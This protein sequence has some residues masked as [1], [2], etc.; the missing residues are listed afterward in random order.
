MV[1]RPTILFEGFQVQIPVDEFSSYG[2]YQECGFW[3]SQ[4]Q[5]VIDNL[6][7]LPDKSKGHKSLAIFLRLHR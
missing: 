1:V 4:F 6:I 2:F 5:E 7:L 3:P